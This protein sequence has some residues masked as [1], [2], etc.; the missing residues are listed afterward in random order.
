M[1]SNVVHF[2]VLYFFN[3]FLSTLTYISTESNVK[4]YVECPYNLEDN[5][6]MIEVVPCNPLWY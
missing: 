5:P 4:E 6:S 2:F 1:L 3:S